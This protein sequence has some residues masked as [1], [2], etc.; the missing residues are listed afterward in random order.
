M[1]LRLAPRRL[2]TLLADL[3]LT[4][5][6]ETLNVDTPAWLLA[7]LAIGGVAVLVVPLRRTFAQLDDARRRTAAW[8][9]LGSV[10]A[11]TPVLAVVPSPRLLGAS[12]LG[13]A[14][15]VAL[16]LDG[17]WFTDVPPARR[18]AAELTGLVALGL[19]FAHL[20]HAPGTSWLMGRHF[21]GIATSFASSTAAL[22][23]RLA[24]PAGAEMVVIRGMAGSFFL[25][26]AL[27]AHGRSPA[28]WRILAQTGHAL[29][30]RR[31]ARTLDLVVPAGQSVFPTGSGYLF[32]DEHRRV[33]VG[34]R[35]TVPGLRVTV[36]EVGAQGPRAVRLAFDRDLESPPFVWITEDH[37]GYSDAPP[38]AIGFGKPL[39]P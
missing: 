15:V 11:L 22:R 33:G 23:K 29:A 27:D 9:L 19:G 18:G 21:N 8:L 20:I 2:V 30:L 6:N 38:P 26:F 36:L 34:D 3:W 1:F 7:A 4:L 28:R 13:V 24:D 39:D 14:P 31:D 32:R 12:L 25:P 5:D 35:F 17:A 10:L 37:D 16:L